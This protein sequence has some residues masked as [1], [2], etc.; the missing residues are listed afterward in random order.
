MKK[1]KSI[2]GW[3]I[4]AILSPVIIFSM[5]VHGAYVIWYRRLVLQECTFSVEKRKDE[6]DKSDNDSNHADAESI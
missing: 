4:L 1:A 5:I 6:T 2:I 3:V